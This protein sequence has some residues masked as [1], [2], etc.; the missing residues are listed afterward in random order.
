MQN[1]TTATGFPIEKQLDFL[2]KNDFY[3]KAIGF[4]MENKWIQHG[5]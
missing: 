5:E 2:F 1:N 4:Q 3:W